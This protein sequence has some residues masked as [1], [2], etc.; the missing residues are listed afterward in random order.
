M[1][2]AAPVLEIVARA[3][4]DLTAVGQ[5]FALVGG[6][7]VSL[8]AEPRTTRDVDFAVAVQ[9]DAEAERVVADMVARRYR[10]VLVLEQERTGRLATV[11]LESALDHVTVVDLLFASSGIEPEVVAAATPVKLGRR[12]IPVARAGHLVAM[13]ILSRDDTRRPQDALDLGNLRNGI[14]A[15][16]IEV[17]RAA[18]ALIEA[19]G[20]NRDRDLS[21]ALA[22][23]ARGLGA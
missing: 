21:G 14:D 5:P 13:K 12:M 20:T 6:F 7:A 4:E 16:E 17:A 22:E 2:V 1:T 3:A 11:R 8:R 19:R 10:V 15:T 9:D 23:W 18:C